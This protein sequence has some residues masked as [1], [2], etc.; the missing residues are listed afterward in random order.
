MNKYAYRVYKMNNRF[1]PQYCFTSDPNE[2]SFFERPPVGFKV[3]FDTEIEAI[4]YCNSRE[5]RNVDQ[6]SV[7]WTS[8]SGL[9][10]A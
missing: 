6:D 4:N 9:K 3:L 8:N 2:W 1:Y 10:G 7:V 5:L